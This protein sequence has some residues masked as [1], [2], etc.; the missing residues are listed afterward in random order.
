VT[1]TSDRAS[2]AVP[3]RS[4]AVQQVD[5][6]I[7]TVGCNNALPIVPGAKGANGCST[8][9]CNDVNSVINQP[10]KSRSYGNVNATSELHIKSAELCEL[11]LSTFSDST[12]Q[13]P[14]QFIRGLDQYFNLRHTPT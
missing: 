11:T 14:L 3:D 9:V 6:V 2:A 13:V 1:G 12:K 10:T 8:S 5:S 4:E 7:N